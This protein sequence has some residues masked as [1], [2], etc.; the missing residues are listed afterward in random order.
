[1]YTSRPSSLI[2][3]LRASSFAAGVITSQDFVMV[4][5]FSS[6]EALASDI[7]V[8]LDKED[9]DGRR[10]P[11][12]PGWGCEKEEVARTLREE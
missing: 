2:F 10:I 1:M 3:D 9:D 12:T 8:L 6:T 7:L 5:S 11:K 4:D